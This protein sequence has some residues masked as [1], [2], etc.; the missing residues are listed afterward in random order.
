MTNTRQIPTA[1]S[2]VSYVFLAS[3]I[4]AFIGIAGSAIRGSFLLDFNI[5]G[6]WIFTGLRRYSVGWRTCALVSIWLTMIVCAVG[7]VYGFFGHDPAYINIFGKR[8]TDI[9]VIWIS[10]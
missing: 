3:G 2:A 1:L 7:F 10:I 8:Y 6:F 5:L 9:P 4:L